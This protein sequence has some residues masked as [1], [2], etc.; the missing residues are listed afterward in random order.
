VVGEAKDMEADGRLSPIDSGNNTPQEAAHS[1]SASLDDPDALAWASM[2]A[3]TDVAI[4]SG[5]AVLEHA[6][7]S[8][9]GRVEEEERGRKYDKL[10]FW[11]TI[12]FVTLSFIGLALTAFF[13]V[14]QHPHNK[15]TAHSEVLVSSIGALLGSASVLLGLLSSIRIRLKDDKRT[16]D[17]VQTVLRHQVD[18]MQR[19]HEME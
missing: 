18:Y 13:L 11:L 6:I 9:R 8:L 10:K 19:I 16:I 14:N 7:I 4:R 15:P 3:W 5:P 17:L 12:I 1:V 2:G